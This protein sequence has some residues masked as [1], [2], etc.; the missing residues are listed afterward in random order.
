MAKTKSRNCD[1][2]VSVRLSSKTMEIVKAEVAR[3]RREQN[4]LVKPATVLRSLIEAGAQ[5]LTR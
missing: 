2:Q 5:K 1:V 4:L 3:I